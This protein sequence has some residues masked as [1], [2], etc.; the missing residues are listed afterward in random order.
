M[1]KH[2]WA[3]I[4][5]NTLLLDAPDARE[6]NSGSCPVALK[7]APASPYTRKMLAV[8]RYRHIPYR[9][10]VGAAAD[11]AGMP[12][13]AVDL[14]PTFYLPNATGELEAVTDSTP[15]IRRFEREVEGRNVLPPNP[16]MRF[17]DSVLEDYG[18]EWVTKAMFHYRW[19]YSRDVEKGG[20]IIPLQYAGIC[21][22][23]ALVVQ[24]KTQFSQRQIGRLSIV[25]SNPTTA[26]LIEAAYV[27][28]LGL[29]DAHL[30]QYPFLMGTR[31]GSSDF[32]L[33]GQFTQL[34]QFDPTSMDVALGV[35]RRVVA[36][37]GIMEDLSGIDANDDGWLSVDAIPETLI[38]L[39]REV[40]RTYVPLL[41]ANETAHHAG[42]KQVEVTIDGER[43]SLKTVPYQA[44]CARWLREEFSALSDADKELATRILRPTGCL[45][46]MSG[47]L[48]N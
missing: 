19:H 28:L 22:P 7:G 3:I 39:M 8:L 20:D 14:L 4:R 6:M 42:E 36:W 5:T 40:G 34:A 35:S 32:A 46:L 13:P 11:K 37:T 15:L 10:M 25:G 31:P 12:K 23:E 17:I 47:S 29:L 21:T 48:V 30:Q 44:K 9:F 1:P 33:Y 24:A 41:L 27:R 18:D 38:N 43:W 26:P 16:V 45:A 2:G